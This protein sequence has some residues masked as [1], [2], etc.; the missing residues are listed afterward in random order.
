MDTAKSKIL[1]AFEF[2]YRTGLWVEENLESLQDGTVVFPKQ[3]R[4]LVV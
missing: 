1:V 2:R 3:S 4:A